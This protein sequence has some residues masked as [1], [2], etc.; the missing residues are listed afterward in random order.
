[1]EMYGDRG[2]SE[3]AAMVSG[4]GYWPPQSTAENS[5]T[6]I[7]VLG[8]QKGRTTQQKMQRNF[9]MAKPEGYRK[10]IRL[11]GLAERL[12]LPILTFVDTP[13]AYPGLET[14]E[15]GQAQA[16]AECIQ[17]MFGLTVPVV[18]VVIG[19]GGS[20]GALAIGVANKVLMQ[21]FSTYSVISPEGCASILWSD[22]K[23]AEMASERLKMAPQDLM[24]LEVIDGII[25]E[26]KGGAHRD[27]PQAV[28]LM[29]SA[30]LKYMSPMINGSKTTKTKTKSTELSFL[31]P[32][33][34][35]KLR[36]QRMAK[37]R[38]MGNIAIAKT[39][40]AGA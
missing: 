12:R 1:M 4:M 17:F 30:L 6:P 21:E 23:L 31:D 11:M 38:K 10:A 19:E 16:I 37:F 26:P 13:G 8:L 34:G 18:A 14:E 15:R 7:L 40:E 35:Q 24:K 39:K 25:P 22:S 20:G 27:W 29:K 28:E 36:E 32:A 2:Y 9:G 33:Q 3:D 5:E